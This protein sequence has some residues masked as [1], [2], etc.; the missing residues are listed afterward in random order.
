MDCQKWCGLTRLR[1]VFD[2]V[3]D[4]LQTYRSEAG[5]TLYDLPDAP[6]PSPDTPAPVRFLGEYD[7]VLLSHAD[8]SR[9]MAPKT[10]VPLPPGDGGVTGTVLVDG[11]YDATWRAAPNDDQVTLTIEPLR[12]LNSAERDDIEAEGLELLT[13]LAATQ[14]TR[15][16]EFARI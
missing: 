9:V 13:F 10:L 8:R 6:R 11:R 7:N 3:A 1:E 16:V 12:P 4:Q 14:P 2:D 15:S 5:A